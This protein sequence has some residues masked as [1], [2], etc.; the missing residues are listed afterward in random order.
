MLSIAA[1]KN[2]P[3]YMTQRIALIVVL[4]NISHIMKT[5]PLHHWIYDY[6]RDT[7]KIAQ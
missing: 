6:T 5:C 7:M 2:S 3:V 1:Y 4:N